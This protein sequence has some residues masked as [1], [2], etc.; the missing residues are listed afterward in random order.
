MVAALNDT[1]AVSSSSVA[2][3]GSA[4]DTGGSSG[5]IGY[6]TTNATSPDTAAQHQAAVMAKQMLLEYLSKKFHLLQV[7][8]VLGYFA[9]FTLCIVLIAYL[10]YNRSVALKGDSIAARK[11][12]LPAFEP[13]LW[14]LG[15][16]TGLYT[17]FM[18][19]ALSMVWF[20]YSIPALA[21]ECIYSGRQ[22]VFLI[23]VVY[24][25]QKSVSI[26]ALRR[27]VVI[28]L[29]LS[30]YTIPL[31]YVLLEENT[32][33]EG[34]SS[35]SYFM[36]TAGRGM[37]MFLYLY[38]AIWPPG[39]A[40]KRTIR[41]Y[42]MFAFIYYTF[43]FTYGELFRNNL[44]EEAFA[45]TY[46]T[47]LWGAMC[48]LVIWR[49]LK[50]D[51]EHWR[52]MGQRACAL[53]SVFRQKHQFSERIS[54][55]GLH[56]LIE[57]HRKYIIDFAYLKIQEKIGMG[58]SATVFNGILH[59]DVPVAIKVYTPAN[60][61]EDTVA[62]FSHEAALCGALNHPNI[63]KF[64]G[65]C[66]FP[67]AICLVSELCQGSLDDVT[68]ANLRHHNSGKEPQHINHQ[69][70]LINLGYMID[71][72]RAV[73]YLHSFSPAFLH[74]D[75]KP[76][77][78]MVD[79]ENNV[80]LTD[81]GESRSLAKAAPCVQGTTSDRDDTVTMLETS[82]ENL[83]HEEDRVLGIS[84]SYRPATALMAAEPVKMTVKGTV[85]YMA[86]ELIKGK[87]GLAEYGEAADVYSLAM[88]MWDIINP[89]AE[90]FPT[91]KNN[92]LQVF[93]FVIDGKRPHIE[94][95]SMHPGL[96]QVIESAWHTDPRMRPSAQNIVHILEAI[97]EELH[98]VFAQELMNEL[99]MDMVAM[100]NHGDGMPTLFTGEHAVSRM[101]D[102]NYVGTTAEAI[103]LGN[104]LMD[105]GLLHHQQHARGFEN[106]DALYFFDEDNII[107]CKPICVQNARDYEQA[108]AMTIH[109]DDAAGAATTP[110]NSQIPYQSILRRSRQYS[111]YST[112]SSR[113]GTTERGGRTAGTRSDRPLLEHGTMCM[114]R[115]YGQRLENLKASRRRFRR[116][117]K[118]ISE[119][120]V[121]TVKL[122]AA[123][124]GAHTTMPD[125]GEFD[126]VDPNLQA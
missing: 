14:I 54:S 28:T 47:I 63:V 88:T 65:M 37:L 40:S 42:C 26:P 125:F 46:V 103:R 71:A 118:A 101:E 22:F 92:H 95:H 82:G 79:A 3:N 8:L 49:V 62:E 85:D 21:T 11:I 121:L 48:P 33:H 35:V 120:N 18:V 53:Q 93:E 86:P 36:L 87:A 122:L 117:F 60:F 74:R 25:L 17:L 81:F 106:A 89:G 108:M 56:V 7:F 72:A 115:K 4:M 55:Q 97:Q 5:S 44:M 66:V 73:A 90:K 84:T 34:Q 105:A 64:Y 15:F 58:S 68:R 91:L 124:T 113:S 59:P 20:R 6:I 96:R 51:T 123:D 16:A 69:Q 112:G 29:V 110:S 19:L 75:I 12:I 99:K 23:V 94:E 78:F 102:M 32:N 98:A 70:P 119:E 83:R 39:R 1:L 77:N 41:E 52:G 114:C 9:M 76:S 116:K 80:K 109:E 30:T 107:L 57:M 50:A 27:T 61:T 126:A 10:R 111:E 24:M 2:P 104:A 38:I 31:Q 43:T 45:M 100:S 67:P 13:L